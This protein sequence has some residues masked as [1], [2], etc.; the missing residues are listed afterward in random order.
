M[1][2]KWAWAQRAWT[3]AT[4]DTGSGDPSLSTA[5][6]GS[7]YFKAITERISEYWIEL[8]QIDPSALYERKE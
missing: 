4:N 6:K 8:A 1:R 7:A 5:E 3:Q 2:E